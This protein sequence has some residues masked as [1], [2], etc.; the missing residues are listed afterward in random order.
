MINVSHINHFTVFIH[1]KRSTQKMRLWQIPAQKNQGMH[2]NMVAAFRLTKGVQYCRDTHT[3]KKSKLSKPTTLYSHI[4]E[5]RL[6][7]RGLFFYFR[8]GGG[9]MAKMKG[10]SSH[11]YCVYKG[12]VPHITSK[13]G[14]KRETDFRQAALQAGKEYIP[15]R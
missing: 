10:K 2:Y 3:H 4:A 8:G 5:G 11:D 15:I 12:Q 14:H 1:A 6:Y 7:N 9:G 13:H